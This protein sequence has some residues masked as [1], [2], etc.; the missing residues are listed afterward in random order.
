MFHIGVTV[1]THPDSVLAG[2]TIHAVHHGER[3][4]RGDNTYS[5]RLRH[6]EA[7]RDFFIGKIVAKAVVVSIEL[8]AGIVKFLTDLVELIHGNGAAPFAQLFAFHM[9]WLGVTVPKLALSQPHRDH[10]FNGI[11]ERPVPK[12]VGL[13]AYL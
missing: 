4:R 6:L 9:L 12:A 1:E 7:A 5:Q 10:T 11:V 8:D 2:L 3:G 13:H